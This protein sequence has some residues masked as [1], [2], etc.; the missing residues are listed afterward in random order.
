MLA[1]IKQT[2]P[3]ANVV[4]TEDGLEALVAFRTG[5]CDFLLSNHWMP[6]MNGPSLIRHV[7]DEAPDLP[8]VGISMEEA[9]RRSAMN[10]GANWFLMKAQIMEYLPSL[11]MRYVVGA[12]TPEADGGPIM[13]FAA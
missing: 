9:D 2:I 5:R 1:I 12:A 10:A 8:I 6:H 13:K 4:S 7:R 3:G 11:L